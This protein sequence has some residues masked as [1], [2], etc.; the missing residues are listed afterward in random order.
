MLKS[1][2]IRLFRVLMIE[3]WNKVEGVERVGRGAG[4]I[5]RCVMKALK[6]RS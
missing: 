1:Q 3:G 6:T 5:Q 2:S 4:E